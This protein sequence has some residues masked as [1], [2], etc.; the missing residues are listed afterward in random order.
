MGQIN[1]Q[2]R[3]SELWYGFIRVHIMSNTP[4]VLTNIESSSI[5][6]E[7]GKE[8]RERVF[9]GEGQWDNRSRGEDNWGLGRRSIWF[10]H[11]QMWS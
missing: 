4:D 6:G 10:K 3:V 1:Y 9:K 2:G 8:N 11:T 7:V 5:S